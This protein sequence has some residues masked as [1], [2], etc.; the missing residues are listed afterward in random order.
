MLA[1]T[2]PAT[3]A[4]LEKRGLQ[5]AEAELSAL[6]LLLQRPQGHAYRAA[7]DMGRNISPN[8]S[9]VRFGKQKKLWLM[10]YHPR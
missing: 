8:L 7:Q 5:A 10:R 9:I 2:D 1:K 3:D 6:P 4:R